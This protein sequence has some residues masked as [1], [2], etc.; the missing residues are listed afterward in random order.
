MALRSLGL[1]PERG[2][3]DLETLAASEAVELFLDRARLAS[4][5]FHLTAT[6]AGAIAEICRRLDGIPL[7][8]ELAA[9]RIKMLSVDQ[10]RSKLDDRF[11]LLVGG[12]HSAVPR[13]QTLQATIQW[14]YDQLAPD[15]Q[16]LFRALSVFSG[17]W[18]LDLVTRFHGPEADAIEIMDRLGRLIDKSLVVVDRDGH[19]EP[20]YSLLETVRQ[21]AQERS[22]E[23]N[24]SEGQ[25]A[26]FA[27]V[28]LDLA[29]RA[30][31]ERF[32]R[33][34]AWGEQLEI[35]H[36]NLRAAIDLLER[37]DPERCLQLVGALAWFFQTR[38]HF[39]EGR[40]L[41]TRAVAATPAA[42]ARPARARALW[43]VANTLTWQG[44]GAS[45]LTWME[46]ALAMWRELGD[47]R[48][49][50]LALEG[51]GWAHLL[52]SNDEAGCH[53]FEESL[54]L[55]RSLGDP[56]LVN[57]A[58]VAL[59]Q[60][61]VALHRV[62]EARPMAQ[63]IIEF[64]SAHG[65]ERNEHFGWHFLADCALVE[66]KCDESLDLYHRSLALARKGGD[67]LEISFEVQGVAMSLAGLG[68]AARALRLAGA[69]HAEWKRLGIDLHI[70]FWDV[71]LDDYLGRARRGLAAAD[72]ERAWDV[73]V[74]TSFDAAIGD[75]LS[76]STTGAL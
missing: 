33:E 57:R 64:S 1:P 25:R 35:E 75:A 4:E 58:M 67:R 17:G 52:A 6:N 2:A 44:D 63:Q 42:P 56:Y 20:R 73:G 32:T 28:M 18:S 36:D 72:A 15:E 23:A 41:L 26:R 7:A 51:I 29:E 12:R 69:V 61:L 11:R 37:S 24:E 43:G 3:S 31:R 13:H 45:A 48:E 68:D 40:E 54:E 55:F 27:D 10:I 50:A 5:S 38:S 9:A 46:E 65:D 60:A 76:L 21:Y 49:V 53:T 30:Y 19:D 47:R 39:V 71:L 8:I 14:S 70:R 16:T 74:N 66:H 34:A 59:A 62:D 22:A